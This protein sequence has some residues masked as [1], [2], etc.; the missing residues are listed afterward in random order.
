MNSVEPIREKNDI[1]NFVEYLKD[2]NERD[3]I[4]AMTGFYSGYRIS[5]LL[6]LKVKD[7]R[8]RD[9]FYFREQK[10][11]KQTKILINPELKKAANEYI[12]CNNLRDNEYMFKSQKGYNQPITRQRAYV[13]LSSAA[14]AIG[15][16]GSFGTHSLRKTMGYHYYK[17]TKDVVTLKMIFNHS[18]IDVT[19]LYIGVT[20]DIINKQL[21]DFK[22]F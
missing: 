5:D 17:Q 12:Y 10:T 20:Q 6:S 3:F 19:L 14:K 16:Q 4:L 8:D 22:L 15:L 21:K 11:N 18:S 7:F 13:I 1:I 9:Y 2:R